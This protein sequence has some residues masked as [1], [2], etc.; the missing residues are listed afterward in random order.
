MN[1]RSR[2]RD[3]QTEDTL[4]KMTVSLRRVDLSLPDEVT[5]KRSKK[6]S[7]GTLAS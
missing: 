1:V 3:R 4:M 2:I 6:P 7:T 5:G